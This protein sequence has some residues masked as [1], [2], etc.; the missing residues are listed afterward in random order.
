MI[1]N[2]EHVP[3]RKGSNYP[4]QFKALVAGR[5]KQRLGDAAGLTNFGVNLVKLAPGSRSALRHWHARQDEFIYVLEGEIALITDEGTQ[6]LKSGMAAGFPSGEA[7]GHHLI[8]QTDTLAVYL[9]I[10]DRTPND[11]VYYPDDDLI[12]KSSAD[13]WTFWHKDNTPYES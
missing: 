5:I 8:N 6:I 10:G 3:S 9:E 1:I 12:A 11:E 2:P 7:N 13:G 4:E